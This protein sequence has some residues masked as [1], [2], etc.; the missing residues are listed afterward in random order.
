M[1]QPFI[2]L[3]PLYVERLEATNKKYF[4]TQSYKAG[5]DRTQENKIASLLVSVYDDPGLA[6][7][8]WNAVRG[9]AMAAVINLNR[10]AHKQKLYEMLSG[11]K[12][13]VYWAV[14]KDSADLEKKIN[15]KYKDNMRRYLERTT[16][17]KFSRD[18]SLRPSIQLVFGELYINLRYG[19]QLIR[20][21]FEE[22]EKV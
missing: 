12:Y 14:V 4:V 3:L 18:A 17:W 13:H 6:E 20:V 16:D 2:K 11:T 21:K 5:T 7:T 9:D 19:A 22:I 15:A 8:H 1:L 10:P